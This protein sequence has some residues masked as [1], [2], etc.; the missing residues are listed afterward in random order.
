MVLSTWDSVQ[1]F[2]PP[3]RVY[4]ITPAG[5]AQ[6]GAWVAELRLTDR[7]LHQFLE[8]YDKAFPDAGDQA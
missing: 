1:S 7:V 2:G 6:L 4:T 3:R 8:Q 5:E